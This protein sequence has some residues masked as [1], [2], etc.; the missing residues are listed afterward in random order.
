MYDQTNHFRSLFQELSF[1]LDISNF[2]NDFRNY[3]T[4]QEVVD[5]VK[6]KLQEE[7]KRK[8]L[9]LICEEVK[10]TCTS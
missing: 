10:N 6:H 4:S 7:E 9:S 3:M 8:Q 2:C 1:W 5:F